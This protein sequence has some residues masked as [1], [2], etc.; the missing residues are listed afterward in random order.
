MQ[1]LA[2]SGDL[3]IPATD[4]LRSLTVLDGSLTLHDGERAFEL[5][6][7]H[8]AALPACLGPLDVE[9]TAAHA[10]LCALA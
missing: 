5:A 6:R 2:G 1:R 3:V 4:R 8:T 7:G 9:L 10:M